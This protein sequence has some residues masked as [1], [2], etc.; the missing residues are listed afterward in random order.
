MQQ[1]YRPF[2]SIPAAT[3][4]LALLAAS[5]APALVKPHLVL[6]GILLLTLGGVLGLNTHF[7]NV[8]WQKAGAAAAA[9]VAARAPTAPPPPPT[10][11]VEPVALSFVGLMTVLFVVASALKSSGTDTDFLVVALIAMLLL[12]AIFLW[13]AG[14]V[15]G[16]AASHGIKAKLWRFTQDR[17]TPLITLYGLGVA[18]QNSQRASAAA[19]VFLLLGALLAG[20]G[21]IPG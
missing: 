9:R 17:E 14:K 19:L 6:A 4:L 8:V 20:V 16:A 3:A 18:L 13:Q 1:A 15:V 12:S 2:F 21:A 10:L 7:G 5:M 11:R